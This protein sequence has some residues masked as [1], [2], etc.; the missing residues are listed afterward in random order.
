MLSITI[1]VTIIQCLCLIICLTRTVYVY[2]KNILISHI[3]LFNNIFVKKVYIRPN[4]VAVHQADIPVN[5]FR[6]KM[7]IIINILYIHCRTKTNVLNLIHFQGEQIH[8]FL[9]KRH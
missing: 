3:N 8:F 2:F 6:K 4:I 7:S 1:I 5:I 9:K